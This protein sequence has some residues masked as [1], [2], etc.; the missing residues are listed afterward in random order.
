MGICELSKEKEKIKT[1][2]TP[3][4]ETDNNNKNNI[5]NTSINNDKDNLNWVETHP[6]SKGQENEIKSQNLPNM[7]EII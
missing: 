5:K 7:K 1:K 3:Q 2:I 6:S 4:I